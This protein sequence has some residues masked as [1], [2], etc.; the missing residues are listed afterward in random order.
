MSAYTL[1]S[2]NLKLVIPRSSSTVAITT[3][4][5]N[6]FVALCDNQGMVLSVTAEC[7]LPM[8][9]GLIDV[10]KQLA[11]D[12]KAARSLSVDRSSAICKMCF[13]FQVQTFP[14]VHCSE[15]WV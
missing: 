5:T 13:V 11:M 6:P 14:A 10:A 12:P 8:A 9:P 2:V 3:D 4:K 1:N 7:S 15:E